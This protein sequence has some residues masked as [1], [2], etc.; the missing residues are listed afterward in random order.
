MDFFQQDASGGTTQTIVRTS[1]RMFIL[2]VGNFASLS[3]PLTM[4]A[5]DEVVVKVK[6]LAS[7]VSVLSSAALID[8]QPQYVFSQ[9]SEAVSLYFSGTWSIL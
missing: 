5:G 2:A 1:P 6:N 3:L 4:V 8:G 9:E 7:G